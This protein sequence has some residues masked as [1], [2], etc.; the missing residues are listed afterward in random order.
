MAKGRRLVFVD[1]PARTQTQILI[2]G[3]GTHPLDPDHV[4]LHVGNTAFGGTFTARLMKEVRSKRG[5]S[6]GAYAR[7]PIDRRR[8]A[9]SMWTFP[10]ATDAAACVALELELLEAWLADG[11]TKEELT[12]SRS[13]LSESYAFDV[14]T[15][16][17]RVRQAVDEEVYGLPSDYHTGYVGRVGQTTL[18]AA[19]AAI[20]KRISRDDLAVVV[21]G[22]AGELAGAIAKAI[23]N[24]ASTEVLPYDFEP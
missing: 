16:F 23:P 9:F 18:D 3:L 14:D 2:G 12:F 11:I 8:E 22:T 24:L 15:P 4:A 6:Y 21:V 1:K 13:Y 7:L 20:K 10:A 17:K 19:N 5:W